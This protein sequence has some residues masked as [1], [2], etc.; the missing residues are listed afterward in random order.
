MDDL[1]SPPSSS[2]RHR[3]R[4][5][6]LGM[7]PPEEE[8]VVNETVTMIS[9][10]KPYLHRDTYVYTELP[11][12]NGAALPALLPHLHTLTTEREAMS[13]LLPRS[14]AKEN[15]LPI[16]L[17]PRLSHIELTVRSGLEGVGLTAAV[18]AAL[19]AGEIACNIVAG[20]RHDHLFVPEERAAMA[21]DVLKALAKQ[22]KKI[23]REQRRG[24]R[25]D[26]RPEPPAL[27]PESPPLP[28]PKTG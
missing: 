12:E 13:L 25:R 16:N 21:M 14:V 24:S 18:S 1:D 2:R 19:S 4:D 20:V 17:S 5:D 15:G 10:M 6:D 27:S 26:D 23:E 22:T 9:N 28:A 8:P 11:Y 7:P 3:P